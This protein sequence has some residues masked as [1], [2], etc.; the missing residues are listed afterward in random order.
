[1][2][3]DNTHICYVCGVEIVDHVYS[4]QRRIIRPVPAPGTVG[5]EK[6]PKDAV[7]P[8]HGGV[9][10]GP[11]YDPHCPTCY[12]E[13]DTIEEMLYKYKINLGEMK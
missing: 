13:I 9:Q 2:Q 5:Y 10:L 7:D 1:M 3:P 6:A 11:E 4:V 12:K 8:W